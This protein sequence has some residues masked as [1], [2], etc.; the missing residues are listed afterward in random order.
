MSDAL[1]SSS[2]SLSPIK[3]DAVLQELTCRAGS[4]PAPP[5]TPQSVPGQHALRS[6]STGLLMN[7]SADHDPGPGAPI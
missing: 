5:G 3:L 1:V 4:L 7:D 2:D 6:M